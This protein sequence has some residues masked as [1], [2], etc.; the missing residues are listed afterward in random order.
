MAS[1]LPVLVSNRCGCA[2][3]LVQE[4]VNGFT[5]DPDDVEEMAQR[6]LELSAFNSSQLSTICAASQRIIS[7]W[8]PERFANGLRDAV[9][10]ALKNPPPRYG[11]LDWLLLRLLMQ[12]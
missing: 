11:A 7:A 4:G 9:A 8:G 1:G 6:L 10:V 5:F 3:D 12:R 2:T